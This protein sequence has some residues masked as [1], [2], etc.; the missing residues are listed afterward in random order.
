M[1]KVSE[2]RACQVLS[3]PRATQRYL[4][5]KPVAD[6]A[7]VKKMNELSTRHKRYGY[8]RITV[9][10]NRGDWNV[11]TT[12]VQRLWRLNRL[13]VPQKTRKRRYLHTDAEGERRL[14][15]TYPGHVWS[16]DF[17]YD[18]TEN[19]RTLK[20]MTLVD[21]FTRECPSI[22]VD[23]RIRAKDVLAEMKRLFALHGAP[24]FIRSDN[25]S[26]FIEH[27]L[28]KALKSMNVCTKYIDPGAPWQNSYVESFNGTFRDE[29]LNLELF[30]TLAEARVLVERWRQEYNTFRPHSS[31][32]NATPAEFAASLQ[33]TNNHQP[34]LRL[35]QDLV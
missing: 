11:S 15:A 8:R 9:L 12:R 32:D 34:A 30:G 20:L 21:E 7:L 5:T 25:G 10:L 35:T 2:R 4:A 3:Q 28:R 18:M 31:L 19:G 27:K 13:Q 23:R 26:E 22:L 6:A 1:L 29:L 14:S 24:E 33:N 17:I 16:Y